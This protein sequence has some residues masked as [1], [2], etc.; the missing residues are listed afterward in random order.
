MMKQPTERFTKDAQTEWAAICSAAVSVHL[1]KAVL[2]RAVRQVWERGAAGDAQFCLYVSSKFDNCRAE[3]MLQMALSWDE[4]DESH[5]HR[6]GGW[7]GIQ[8]L[9]RLTKS[10]RRSLVA[11]MPGEGPYSIAKIKHNAATLKISAPTLGIGRPTST[12]TERRYHELVDYVITVLRDHPD[13]VLPAKLRA[14]F[15]KRVLAKVTAALRA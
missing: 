12:E 3:T 11:L 5:W 6:F 9:M 15:P 4:F 10:Q 1:R 2:A 7:P 14:G 13:I 8:F